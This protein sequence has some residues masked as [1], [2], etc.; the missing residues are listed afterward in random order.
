MPALPVPQRAC[1][2]AVSSRIC[3]SRCKHLFSVRTQSYRIRAHPLQ[4]PHFQT[5]S[6]SQVLGLTTSTRAFR[7]THGTVAG[8][9][10]T[11]I[12]ENSHRRGIS[13]PDILKGEVLKGPQVWEGILSAFEAPALGVAADPCPKPGH[14]PHSSFVTGWVK[15]AGRRVPFP[16][17]LCYLSH[18]SVKSQKKLRIKKGTFPGEL[19]LFHSSS[20]TCSSR[21]HTVLTL[22]SPGGFRATLQP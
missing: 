21:F 12:S 10:K 14:W 11:L 20:P 19:L 4:T 3:V 8:G 18:P 7:G 16:T 13:T 17:L 6:R 15:D 1:L 9:R 22:S 5:K 2:R